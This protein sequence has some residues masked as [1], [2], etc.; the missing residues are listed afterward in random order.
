MKVVSVDC[1]SKNMAVCVIEANGAGPITASW[2]THLDRICLRGKTIS[3]LVVA[4]KCALQNLEHLWAE[5]DVF[6]IEQQPSSNIRMK[7]ISHCLEMYWH[8]MH[9]SAAVSF[10]PAKAALERIN[11]AEGR[12]KITT[13]QTYGVRKARSVAFATT[14][15]AESHMAGILAAQE[16]KDDCA[17]A[18]MHGVAWMLRSGRRLDLSKSMQN[19][20]SLLIVD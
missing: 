20:N 19:G 17:D 13:K 15:L 2:V 16:K 3:D 12:A 1:G 4:L 5:T 11:F 6:V 9:P 7:V 10:S 8:T 18:L 14:F